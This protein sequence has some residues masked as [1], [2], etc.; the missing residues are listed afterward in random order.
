MKP[1]RVLISLQ[2]PP[3]AGPGGSN[4]S[5]LVST[6]QYTFPHPSDEFFRSAN[7]ISSEDNAVFWVVGHVIFGAEER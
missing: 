3:S 5:Y 4:R 1:D 7:A 2:I 6:H